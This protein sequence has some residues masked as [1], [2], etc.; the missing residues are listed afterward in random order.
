MRILHI[1][2]YYYPFHGGIE[3]V[4]KNTC[5]GLAEDGHDIEVLC[6]NTSF[7][8]SDEMINGVKVSRSAEILKLFGQSLVPFLFFQLRKKIKNYD[9]IHVHGPNP[10][11]ELFCLFLP[12]KIPVVVTYHSDV[13]KQ[14]FLLH[15]Y[16]PILKLF[17]NRCNEIYV[18]TENHIKYSFILPEY[19]YKCRI[20][21]F[22]IPVQHLEESSDVLK[23]AAEFRSQYGQYVLS[24]GRLVGYK[25]LTHLIEAATQF[26]QSVLIV[27][28]GPDHKKLKSKIKNLGLENQV[29]LIGR[30]DDDVDFAAYF[31]G[32]DVFA[33]PSVTN[34]ENFG[35]V[36]LEAMACRKPVVTTNLKSGVPL[37]GEKGKTTLVVEPANSD[38]LSKAIQMLLNNEELR[39]SFSKNS[40]NRF[41]EN[42]TQACMVDGHVKAYQELFNIEDVQKKTNLKKVS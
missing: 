7:K 12:K 34:N 2:K 40:Y 36:Q 11:I 14:K 9:V 41:N 32:C 1:G 42:Y 15:F 13:V 28:G 39:I 16:K 38:A 29:H 19:R 21:P 5:E 18:A 30:V 3:S 35:I 22:G 25:G 27:G 20:I 17:L 37:V 23:K 26:D 8:N 24:V 6:S 10:L 31:H 33:L 4:V